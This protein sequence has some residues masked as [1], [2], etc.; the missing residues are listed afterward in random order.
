MYMATPPLK[1]PA[2][3]KSP[4]TLRALTFES[5]QPSAGRI[6][7]KAGVRLPKPDDCIL[8]SRGGDRI[9]RYAPP[10]AAGGEARPRYAGPAALSGIGGWHGRGGTRCSTADSTVRVGMT[11]YHVSARRDRASASVSNSKTD[12]ARARVD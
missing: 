12:D 8:G 7:A 2:S 5:H 9:S 4:V 3:T 6:E 11:G 10:P 1:V